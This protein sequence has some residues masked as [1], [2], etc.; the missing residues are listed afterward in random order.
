VEGYTVH[1]SEACPVCGFKFGTAWQFEELP[2]EVY[3]FVE[4]MPNAV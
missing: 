2:S 4:K 1:P 3:N